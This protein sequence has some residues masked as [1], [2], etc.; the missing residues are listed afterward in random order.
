MQHRCGNVGGNVGG[1]VVGGKLLVI[2]EA[3]DGV[4]VAARR[5]DRALELGG[6]PLEE[7]NLAEC[8][9]TDQGAAV[10]A[11]ALPGTR[12]QRSPLGEARGGR[13]YSTVE[14]IAPIR[15]VGSDDE[16]KGGTKKNDFV[17]FF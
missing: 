3:V 9:M 12:A 15:H 1:S 4:E 11:G 10:L 16:K 5:V 6:L 8:G 7:L 17:S 2:V 14:T 13:M